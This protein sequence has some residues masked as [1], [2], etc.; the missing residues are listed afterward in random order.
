MT[1]SNKPSEKQRRQ[2]KSRNSTSVRSSPSLHKPTQVYKTDQ[3]KA[4]FSGRQH[5]VGSPETVNADILFT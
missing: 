4:M 5:I 2:V 3:T 1:A